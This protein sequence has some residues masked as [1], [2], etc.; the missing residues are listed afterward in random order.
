MK[1]FKKPDNAVDIPYNDIVRF[2]KND[3]LPNIYDVELRHAQYL[4]QFSSVECHI[5]LY[6][7]S[8]Q[9]CSNTLK[10][11]PYE[12]YVKDILTQQKSA[13]YPLNSQF[14]KLFGI[15]MGVLITVIFF[16]FKPGDLFSVESIVSVLGAYFFGKELWGEIERILID[17]SKTWRIRYIEQY[18]AYRLEKHTTLTHYSYFA[19]KHRY[20]KASLIPEKIDFIEKS[21]SQTVRM[22]F[23]MKDICSFQE[24]SSHILSIHVDADLVEAFEREGFLLGVKLSFNRRVLGWVKSLELFQSLHN[25]AKGCLDQ[26][27]KWVDG[28]IFYRKTLRFGRF[29]MF[30]KHGLIHHKSIIKPKHPH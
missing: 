21:N 18:Y 13:Y 10:F 11:Y 2:K 4:R 3:E 16:K 27:G 12:E 9:I 17:V 20:G 30:L 19:K 14:D 8:R 15:F 6:P 22:L 1:F 24:T 7:Y 28:G 26:T 23:N 29:K 5:V 25:Y